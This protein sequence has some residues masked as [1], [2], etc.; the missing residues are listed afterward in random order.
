MASSSPSSSTRQPSAMF[1][2][3]QPLFVA[4]TRTV[5]L[6]SKIFSFTFC[7]VF[8]KQYEFLQSI[9]YKKYTCAIYSLQNIYLCNVIFTK[10]LPV[11]RILYRIFTFAKYSLQNIYFCK[12]F[13]A[14]SFP[15][16]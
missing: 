2:L 10:Y 15:P 3:R 11:Q 8:L 1:V 12:V 16:I 6:F 13:C 4:N 14:K 9:P 5:T 7:K